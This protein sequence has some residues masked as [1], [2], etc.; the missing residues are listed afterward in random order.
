MSFSRQRRRPV[1]VPGD[2]ESELVNLCGSRRRADEMIRAEMKRRPGFS[3]IGAAL[4]LVT[5]L[6]HQRD[7]YAKP[8]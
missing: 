2:Y 7:G 8:L 3:R 5:R 4:A 1:P 6:R